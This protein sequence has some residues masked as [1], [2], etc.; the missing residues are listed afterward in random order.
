MPHATQISQ[1]SHVPETKE[2]LD[3]AERKSFKTNS[4]NYRTMAD[5]TDTPYP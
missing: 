2:D 4:T 3:W 5:K 1:Y